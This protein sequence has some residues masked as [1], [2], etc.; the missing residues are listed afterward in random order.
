M[1]G[2]LVD[3]KGHVLTT[4]YNVSGVL[5]SVEVLFPDGM[6]RPA[7]LV[8][9]DRSDDLA[10]VRVIDPP[11]NLNVPEVRWTEPARLQVGRMVVVLGP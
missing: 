9:I 3:R 1:S 4:Y 11:G 2:L 5:H 7:R 6:R 10:L 8:A